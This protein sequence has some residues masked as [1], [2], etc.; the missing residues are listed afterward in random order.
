M[1]VLKFVEIMNPNTA[2]QMTLC[3]KKKKNSVCGEFY[4]CQ[5]FSPKKCFIIFIRVARMKLNRMCAGLKKLDNNILKLSIF[6]ERFFFILRNGEINLKI[7]SNFFS[8]E[9]W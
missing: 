2:D 1:G 3:K 7:D 9:C 6:L 5:D 8:Y 4:E